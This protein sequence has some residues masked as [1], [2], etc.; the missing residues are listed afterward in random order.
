MK[1][2]YDVQKNTQNSR[3]DVA[4]QPTQVERKKLEIGNELGGLLCML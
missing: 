1:T 2:H 3:S 4:V